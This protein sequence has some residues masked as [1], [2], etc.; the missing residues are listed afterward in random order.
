MRGS[1][2]SLVEL[3][4]RVFA[5][6]PLTVRTAI[7]RDSLKNEISFWS[8]LDI[9]VKIER[10]KREAC[11][12]I[13]TIYCLLKRKLTDLYY[14]EK[15]VWPFTYCK[16]LD[17]LNVK[18]E[19]NDFGKDLVASTSSSSTAV[20]LLVIAKTWWLV[21]CGAIQPEHCGGTSTAWISQSIVIVVQWYTSR[22]ELQLQ[23]EVWLKMIKMYYPT[24]SVPKWAL[25][26]V[27]WVKRAKELHSPVTSMSEH[28]SKNSDLIAVA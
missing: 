15:V 12:T 6:I 22:G 9:P 26:W 11:T 18:C 20:V 25:H 8:A 10:K 28:K 16:V 13:C 23:Q 17:W 4:P 5:H 14:V 2:D 19:C 3:S 1:R 21:V 24:D 7:T 27:K